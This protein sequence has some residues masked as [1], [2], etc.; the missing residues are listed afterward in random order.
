MWDWWIYHRA[1]HSI[2][3]LCRKNPGFAYVIQLWIEKYIEKQK[4]SD[5]LKLSTKQFVDTQWEYI[6][7]NDSL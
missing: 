2:E 5:S 6:Q 7:K 1:F 3:R 4:L